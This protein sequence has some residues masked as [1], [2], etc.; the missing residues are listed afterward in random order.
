MV[1]EPAFWSYLLLESPWPV[2]VALVGV[3]AVLRVIGARRRNMRLRVAAI[4]AL[5]LAAGL[6]LLAYGVTT[7]REHVL[8]RTRALIEATQPMSPATLDGFIRPSA[9]IAVDDGPTL[10]AYEQARPALERIAVATQAIQQTRA[11][12]ADPGQAVSEVS[13]MTRLERPPSVQPVPSRWRF[14][15][16]RGGD[17]AWRVSKIV[18]LELRGEAVSDELGQRIKNYLQ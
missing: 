13:L 4:G 12:L 9:T 2:I 3:W 1:P 15:W 17:G 6:A 7:D 8:D 10:M 18:L 16:R 14:H 5:G 11:G